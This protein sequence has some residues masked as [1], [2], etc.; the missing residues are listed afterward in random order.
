MVDRLALVDAEAN[1]R[2]LLGRTQHMIGGFG[3]VVGEPPGR[4]SSSKVVEVI[5]LTHD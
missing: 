5:L 2:Y 4:L 1:R 3:K